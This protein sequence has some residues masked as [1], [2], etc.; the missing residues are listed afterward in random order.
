MACSAAC[1]FGVG[2]QLNT[3]QL[4]LTTDGQRHMIMFN[5]GRIQYQSQIVQVSSAFAVNCKLD[6]LFCWHASY[7][8]EDRP[9]YFEVKANARHSRAEPSLI[10]C[11]NIMTL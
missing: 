9:D 2:V 5:Y 6:L 1:T 7:V 10:H 8:F 11:Q 4:V 3:F